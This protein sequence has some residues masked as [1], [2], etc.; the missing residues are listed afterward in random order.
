MKVLFIHM[1]DMHIKKEVPYSKKKIEKLAQSL[2]KFDDIQEVNIICTG[3]LVNAA[4]KEE[5]TK[6]YSFFKNLVKSIGKVTKCFVKVFFVPGNHDIKIKTDIYNLNEI[7]HITLL[8]QKENMETY[9]DFLQKWYGEKNFNFSRFYDIVHYNNRLKNDA[10]IG[11]NL[12]NTAPFSLKE[13]MDKEM[14]YVCP[15]SLSTFSNEGNLNITLMHHSYEW[16]HEN[17]KEDLTD[18]IFTNSDILFVGHTHESKLNILKG[19]DYNNLLISNCGSFD[20]DSYYSNTYYNVII[21]N[22][23]TNDISAI[24]Y[25][26]DKTDQIFVSDIIYDKIKIRKNNLCNYNEKFFKMIR[27]DEKNDI[28]SNINDYF[29][30]PELRTDTK[31]IHIENM[32]KLIKYIDEHKCISIN[33]KRES[34]KTTLLKMLY[35]KLKEIKAI[36]FFNCSDFEGKKI[37]NS[38]NLAILEQLSGKNQVEKYKQISK[39]NKAI[40]IDDFDLIKDD[41]IKQQII[42]YLKKN[43]DLVILS[44]SKDISLTL[45]ED[46]KEKFLLDIDVLKISCFTIRQRKELI[47]KLTAINSKEIDEN[48]IFDIEKSINSIPFLITMGNSFV[49]NYIHMYLNQGKLLSNESKQNFNTLFETMLRKLVID[50][51]KQDNID[52]YLMVLQNLAYF[53]HKNKKEYI[54]SQ[55]IDKIIEE[56]NKF[57]GQK[58]SENEF[59]I[60]MKNANILKE[61]NPNQYLFVNKMYLAY[62]VAKHIY[63]QISNEDDYTDFYSI[64][65]NICFGINDDIMLFIIYISQKLKLLDYV[66]KEIANISKEWDEFSFDK[67]NVKFIYDNK[68]KIKE[69]EDFSDS[70][71][72]KI[73]NEQVDSEITL[74]EDYDISCEG[75]YDYDESKVDE[76]I[77]QVT[78]VLKGLELM[79]RGL[80]S[81]NA[82]LPLQ[83]QEEIVKGIYNITNK[84]LYELLSKFDVDYDSFV[85]EICKEAG[86]ENQ[87]KVKRVI[88][89]FILEFIRFIYFKI[90]SL[91]TSN[92]TFD[93]IKSVLYNENNLDTKLFMLNVI[94]CTNRDRKFEDEFISILKIRNDVCISFIIKNMVINRIIGRDLPYEKRNRM[95]NK[96]NENAI[97]YN[98]SE[99]QIILE[100]L[101]CRS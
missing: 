86:I 16:F 50:N 25:N 72:E 13:H 46:F 48:G 18:Y 80:Q 31:D 36:L 53:I 57:Y 34:G 62:F 8:K 29:V 21:Y 20:V 68:G 49:L 5:Y 40:I 15:E 11:I 41:N 9:Y 45:K 37:N 79:S 64:L 14:H 65:N 91:C 87:D 85:K 99:K 19:N 73:K 74:L 33:G 69:I 55:E 90:S 12:I 76:E 94:D 96:Y 39:D 38:I 44:T 32:D 67:K 84:L 66:F 100:K 58:V 97:L 81:F 22:T 83:K 95:I 17:I 1:G 42:D 98:I 26:W 27:K 78:C 56:Y 61:S 60:S 101:K 82:S 75:L 92:Q 71:M 35:L 59:K 10:C 77:N 43:F 4:E 63:Y 93:V 23:D 28:G 88:T 6:V 30:F 70:K 7:N 54:F 3:D 24:K 47:K 52:S 89:Y 2:S 51:T